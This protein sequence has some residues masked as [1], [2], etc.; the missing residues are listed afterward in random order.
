MH[1][2]PKCDIRSAVD[3]LAV[4]GQEVIAGMTTFALSSACLCSKSAS[5]VLRVFAWE[6]AV[7]LCG[8]HFS[9][10]TEYILSAPVCFGS[11]PAHL[12]PTLTKSLSES[13][14]LLIAVFG[15]TS[16]SIFCCILIPTHQHDNLHIRTTQRKRSKVWSGFRR[17]FWDPHGECVSTGWTAHCQC[18]TLWIANIGQLELH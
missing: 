4:R 6:I 12:L 8:V 18:A 1:I 2:M 16:P 7:Q 5:W 15:S 9:S 10:S 11:S 14:S 13:T 17:S 3:I